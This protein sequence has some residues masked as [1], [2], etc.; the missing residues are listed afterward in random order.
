METAERRS[1]ALE[2]LEGLAQRHDDVLD[3]LDALN[4]RIEAVIQGYQ[5]TRRP[6]S[7]EGDSVD[8]HSPR[9]FSE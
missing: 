5:S 7:P 9:S 4:R 2:F 6:P 8:Q 3:Q 1:Q